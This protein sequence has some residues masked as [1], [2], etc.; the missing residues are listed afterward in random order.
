MKQIRDKTRMSQFVKHKAM[1]IM[2]KTKQEG[3]EERKTYR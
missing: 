2:S 3:I 1:R